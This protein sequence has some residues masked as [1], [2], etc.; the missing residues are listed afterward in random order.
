MRSLASEGRNDLT[1]SRVGS[2]VS[3]SFHS[4]ST[5]IFSTPRFLTMRETAAPELSWMG[6]GET[7]AEVSIS[8]EQ[9]ELARE[10]EQGLGV[11]FGWARST[12]RAG[13]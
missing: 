12:V 4:V 13:K 5:T 8:M 9:L 6:R 10:G 11:A 1:I 3:I 7:A 2:G